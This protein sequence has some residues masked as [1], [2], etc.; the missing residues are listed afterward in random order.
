MDSGPELEC[1]GWLQARRLRPG[2]RPRTADGLGATVRALHWNQGEAH[3][4]TLTVAT[5]HT[6]FVGSAHVLVHNADGYSAC[7]FLGGSYKLLTD[8]WAELAFEARHIIC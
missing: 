4:Y 3:D 2:D 8:F 7:R 1:A 6:F 5:D